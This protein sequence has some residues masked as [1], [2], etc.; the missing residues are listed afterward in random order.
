[1][2]KQEQLKQLINLKGPVVPSDVYSSLGLN[3]LI[4]SAILSEMV[5]NKI[6]KIS[7]LKFGSSPLY[8]LPGQESKLEAFS[9]HLPGPEREACSFLKEK[10]ILRESELKPVTRAALKQIKDFAVPLK[11]TH[12][13]Q[14]EIFWKW[15]LLSN[16]KAS[17]AIKTFLGTD[18]PKKIEDPKEV[19]IMGKNPPEPIKEKPAQEKE[20]QLQTIPS[21]T[22]NK[23][24]TKQQET[25]PSH[26][27][28]KTQ[29]STQKP[30]IK[31]EET[32][33]I[34]EEKSTPFLD[35]IHTYFN[36][37]KIIIHSKEINKRKTEG[38]LMI[39]LPSAVGD[40][41]YFCRIKNKKKINDA[42][43]ASAYVQG[44][45]SKLPTLFITTGQLTKKAKEMLN[46]QFSGMTVKE[47]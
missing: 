32:K 40:L 1:M 10:S 20:Q 13:S 18:K 45:Q 24:E 11:V 2:D 47:L 39:T 16:E 37:N 27:T 42:D 15:H 6:L 28:K 38:D 35:Q 19:D 30:L 21:S 33:P 34:S 46:M 44:Q 17:E 12:N 4:T 41:K 7:S 14:S 3:M 25:S 8:Y 43:L 31:K 9:K 5:S 23:K 26:S 22:I 36:Q 29:E